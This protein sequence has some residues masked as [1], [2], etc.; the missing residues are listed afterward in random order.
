MLTGAV[1]AGLFVQ[2]DG[3]DGTLRAQGHVD[4]DGLVTSS[5]LANCL[6]SGTYQASFQIAEF[7]ILQRPYFEL[8]TTTK[9]QGVRVSRF[10]K[11][12]S[13]RSA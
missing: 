7:Y 12:Y 6:E 2:L 10:R 4:N 13:F 5:D 9:M 3:Y 8:A 11:Q 1:A